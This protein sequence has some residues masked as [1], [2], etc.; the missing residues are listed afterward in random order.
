[1]NTDLL[2]ELERPL[3]KRFHLG[4]IRTKVNQISIIKKC[5]RSRS[6]ITRSSEQNHSSTEIPN[7]KRVSLHS[8]NL[9]TKLY[10]SRAVLSAYLLSKTPQHVDLQQ[11]IR[12]DTL[13]KPVNQEHATMK[14]SRRRERCSSKKRKSLPKWLGR[15]IMN[16][17]RTPKQ[18]LFNR[19]PPL[20]LVNSRPIW[21]RIWPRT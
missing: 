9:I 14:R 12:P 13:P 6:R 1:M 19:T 21:L 5:K 17:S 15:G 3:N 8:N 18:R 7:N 2:M 20:G 10:N 4:N 16:C 11:P